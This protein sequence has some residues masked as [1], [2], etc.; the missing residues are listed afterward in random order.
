M[1]LL[2]FED[3]YQDRYLY[4]D[5]GVEALYLVKHKNPRYHIAYKLCIYF[6]RP[7]EGKYALNASTAKTRTRLKRTIRILRIVH[8]LKIFTRFKIKSKMNKLSDHLSDF[9]SKYRLG[10]KKVPSSLNTGL[11]QRLYF[12]ITSFTQF[13]VIY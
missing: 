9:S 4:F 13:V 7:H 12:H 10:T 2:S 6:F 3:S 1:K 8:Q 5:S 11:Y